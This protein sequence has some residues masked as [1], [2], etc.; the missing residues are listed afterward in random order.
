MHQYIETVRNEIEAAASQESYLAST[1]F[2]R[3]YK[4]FEYEDE[5]AW[6][7]NDKEGFEKVQHKAI[8]SIS[9]Q[10]EFDV[11]EEILAWQIA[12][13]RDIAKES[14]KWWVDYKNEKFRADDHFSDGEACIALESTCEKLGANPTDAYSALLEVELVLTRLCT[15][16]NKSVIE[17]D[18]YWQFKFH[19]KKKAPENS[20]IYKRIEAES[21]QKI[22]YKSIQALK[23]V[24]DL[25]ERYAKQLAGSDHLLW[26]H[27]HYLLESVIHMLNGFLN[28]E[29]IEETDLSLS[30]WLDEL[31]PKRLESGQPNPN[32][33]SGLH[34]KI[35]ANL[36]QATQC[37]VQQT[38]KRKEVFAQRDEIL[39]PY[40]HEILEQVK[41][42]ELANLGSSKEKEALETHSY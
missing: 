13:L 1:L 32:F 24:S 40:F 10:K 22:I 8:N 21:K 11:K 9:K 35:I 17:L 12:M 5:G 41:R 2:L 39:R 7:I 37:M 16:C 31:F 6:K 4:D 33:Q 34:Q 28:F 18:K 19:N 25:C 36:T 14:Y 30:K 42:V 15:A 3:M 20:F 23:E 26:M 27:P 29:Y 38:V